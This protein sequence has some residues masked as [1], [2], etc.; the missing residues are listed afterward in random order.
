M[1]ADEICEVIRQIFEVL[2]QGLGRMLLQVHVKFSDRAFKQ[3][4]TSQLLNDR[5]DFV[6]FAGR[7]LFAAVAELRRV[8]RGGVCSLAGN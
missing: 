6:G 1:R 5:L 8:L 7:L 3:I 4:S 2:V